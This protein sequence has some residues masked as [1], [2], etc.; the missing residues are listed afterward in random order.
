MK[1]QKRGNPS[2]PDILA[3][4]VQRGFDDL[5]KFPSRL[6]RYAFARSR[7]LVN[8]AHIDEVLHLQHSLHDN[9]PLAA[10]RPKIAACGEYLAF[11]QYYTVGKIR[12]SAANFCKCHLLCPLCAIRRGATTLK[13]YLD[14][15]AVIQQENPGLRLSMLTLT[16]KNGDDLG[17]RFD[18]LKKSLK[19]LLERRRKVLAGARGWHSEFA[20]I[21]G[22]VGS[23]ETTKDGSL[24]GSKSGWHPHVHM[25]VLHDDAFDY[26]VLQ[27]EW[28]KITGD[29]HVLNVSPAKHP[30]DPAQDFLE[31]FKYA[32]KFSQLTP[33]DNI[34]AFNVLRSRR[35]L[36]SAGLF[37]GVKVPEDLTDEPLDGLP[38]VELFYR[39]LPGRGYTLTETRDSEVI[40]LGIEHENREPETHVDT[41]RKERKRSP[42]D[43]IEIPADLVASAKK[44]VESPEALRAWLG[45][46]DS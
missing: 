39:Y 8:L 16:V 7:A 23:Y 2:E 25:L 24:D 26:A 9:G 14:R 38:Y 35:L 42:F 30:D 29:S 15:Y 19:T 46:D 31:V 34:E 41:R 20:K 43:L 32:V 17:E 27:E 36:F 1:P 3:D 12:L 11:R 5:G 37:W 22:L 18:H 28:L 6:D 44:A 13:A 33:A 10:I 4:E 40:K 45:P 21:A